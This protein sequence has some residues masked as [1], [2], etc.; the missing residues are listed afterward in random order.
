MPKTDKA[1]IGLHKLRARKSLNELSTNELEAVVQSVKVN[2][3]N[4]QDAADLHNIK[5]T[6]VQSI[7]SGLKKD[8]DFI[9]KRKE[10]IEAKL[11]KKEQVV[12]KVG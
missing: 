12:T 4:Y 7:M 6:L 8:S 9:K 11:L 2:F 1:H 3:L 10:K 5:P